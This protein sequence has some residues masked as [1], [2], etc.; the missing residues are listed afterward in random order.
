MTPVGGTLRGLPFLV[1][2]AVDDDQLVLLD[3]GALAGDL[4]DVTM[5]ASGAASVQMLDNPTN[6]SATATGTTLVSMWQTDSVVLAC[7][8]AFGIEQLRPAIASV[9]DI[10]WGGGPSA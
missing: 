7:V 1:S 5:R 4:G 9:T 3:A 6:N 2:E 8:L 10:G